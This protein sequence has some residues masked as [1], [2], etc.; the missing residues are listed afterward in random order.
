M[1]A[2]GA[3]LVEHMSAL[4]AKLEAEAPEALFDEVVFDTLDGDWE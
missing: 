4:Q 3:R 1:L 2:A